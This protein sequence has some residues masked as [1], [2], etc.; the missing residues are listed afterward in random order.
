MGGEFRSLTNY[1]KDNGITQRV[2]CPYTPKQNGCAERKHRHIVKLGCALLHYASVPYKYWTYAFDIAAYTINRLHIPLIDCLLQISKIKLHMSFYFLT[3]PI[4]MNC[5]SSGLYVIHGLNHT[6]LTSWHLNHL[7]VSFWDIVKFIRGILVL[8]FPL[9][10]FLF[11][12]MFYFLG[13][14][15]FFES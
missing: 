3:N 9:N 13:R 2:S 12:I 15:F 14:C 6:L 11:H 8:I 1:L 4:M 10:A 5:V 7:D